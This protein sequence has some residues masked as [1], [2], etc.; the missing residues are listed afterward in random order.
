MK[1]RF[2]SI[3]FYVNPY[4]TGI[5]YTV[6]YSYIKRILGVDKSIRRTFEYKDINIALSRIAWLS[7]GI[8]N[9]TNRQPAAIQ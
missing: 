3:A 8:H 9:N 1:S 4:K 6:T 2:S 7:N 5:R